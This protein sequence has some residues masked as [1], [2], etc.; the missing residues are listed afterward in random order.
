MSLTTG[1][2]PLGPRPAGR[3][4]APVP[5]GVV[6]VEP[7]P[8]RV[9]ALDGSR[10]VVDSEGVLLVHRSGQPPTYAF[11]EADVDGVAAEPVPEAPG[12][13]AVAWGA[14]DAWFEEN[15]MVFYHP[16]NPYHRVDCVPT[17]RRLTVR[18]GRVELVDTDVTTGLYETSLP[19]R[20][21]VP[22]TAVRMD[23]LVPSPTTWHCPYK[24][25]A[26]YW[27]AV[28]DGTRTTDVAWSYD[29]PRPECL[30]IGGMLCFDENRA[31]VTHDL[32]A[33]P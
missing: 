5:A 16:R 20:L 29:A 32:P 10:Y 19:P 25:D 26:S 3:F 30:P 4:S 15:E 24:G 21:Y 28:I 2:G 6:Y 9:R 12:H 1:H 22:R 11:P 18:I 33:P 7:F 27:T 14:V 17:S 8:R 23:V 31:D 13:L